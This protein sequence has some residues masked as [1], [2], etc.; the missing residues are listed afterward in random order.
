MP[1]KKWNVSPLGVF[2]IYVDKATSE[3]ERNSSVAIRDSFG[4]VIAACCKYLQG[5]FFVLEVEA[6]AVECGI[7]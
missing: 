1:E 6:L 2:K 4:E 3:G 7:L 5:K